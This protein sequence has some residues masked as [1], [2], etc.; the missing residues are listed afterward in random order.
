MR[1][2]L[3]SI[4]LALLLVACASTEYII[5]TQDG[6]LIST[7]GKPELQEDTGMYKYE[8]KEGRVQYIDKSKVTQI[9]ER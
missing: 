8:D 3:I 2:M 5:G 6:Q 9:M 7:Y 1:N 4:S